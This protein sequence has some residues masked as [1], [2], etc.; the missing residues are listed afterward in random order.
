MSTM[1]EQGTSR[2]GTRLGIEWA[3]KTSFTRY[4]TRAHGRCS[5]TDGAQLL[6]GNR[7]HWPLTAVAEQN[8]QWQAQCAGDLRFSAHGGAMF[9]VLADP[10]LRV[11]TDGRA[12]LIISTALEG[13]MGARITLAD[14]EP[15]G[16]QPAAAATTEVAV[17]T[18]W[19][20]RRLQLT[21]EAVPV[22]GEVY[23]AGAPLAD[24]VLRTAGSPTSHPDP[25]PVAPTVDRSALML[26]EQP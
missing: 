6:P 8:G 2:A 15:E 5:I 7:F 20:V 18:Q 1:E 16:P 26:E 12:Q 24:L 10:E 19:T 13:R 22:F 11:G 25:V 14:G 9:V 23:A 4:V 21:P 17:P 3:V